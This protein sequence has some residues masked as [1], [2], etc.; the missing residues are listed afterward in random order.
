MLKGRQVQA[1]EH[2]KRELMVDTIQKA[3]GVRREQDVKVASKSKRGN[4]SEQ[5]ID[6]TQAM[7]GQRP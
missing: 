2:A 7:K 3:C 5:E 4:W 6:S 1:R